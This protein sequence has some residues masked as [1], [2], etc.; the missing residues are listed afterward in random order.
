MGDDLDAA[1]ST[2]LYLRYNPDA[3]LSGVYTGFDTLYRGAHLKPGDLPD[4]VYLDLDIYHPQCRSLGHHIVRYSANDRLPGFAR[5]CNFNEFAGRSVSRGFVEK[6]PLGTVHSLLWLYNAPMPEHPLAEAL[7]WLA[8]SSFINGQTGR[9]APNVARWVREW[10][11]HPG[12]L[13]G[14][15]QIDTLA[16][17]EKMAKLQAF[18]A[19]N[20]LK[21]GKGQTHSRHL[22]LTGFQCQPVGITWPDALEEYLLK[23]LKVLA[24]I[25]GWHWQ[26]GQIA[27]TNLC[28][29]RGQRST[30][31][32]DNVLNNGGLARFLA[33][34][35][36]FSYAFPYRGGINYTRLNIG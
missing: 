1:L 19:K 36:V 10:I 5:N 28:S 35:D 34:N 25:T 30:T 24:D 14:L 33:K 16:F 18:L 9:F 2:L 7:I 26:P 31:S 8:D 6:Y 20:G 4:C 23:L 11:P 3:V 12:L 17:E 29:I 32:V 13:R 27:L 15:E 21:Q 22:Q